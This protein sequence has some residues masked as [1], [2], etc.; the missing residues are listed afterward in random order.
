VFVKFVALILVFGATGIGVLSVR[1]SRLQAVHEMAE[2]RQRTLQ[3]NEQAGEI[4]SLIVRSCTPQRVHALMDAQGEFVPAAATPAQVELVQRVIERAS[5][6]EPTPAVSHD[7]VE[8]HESDGTLV[9][10]LEDGTRVVFVE[11]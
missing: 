7:G 6:P 3:S 1:Q 8:V 4:R 5:E 2:A 9:F 10:T 11:E